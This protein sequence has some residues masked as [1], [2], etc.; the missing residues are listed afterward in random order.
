LQT[1][2]SREYNHAHVSILFSRKIAELIPH[3]S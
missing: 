1:V 2:P 3:S